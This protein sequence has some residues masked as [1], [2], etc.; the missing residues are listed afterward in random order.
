M[1]LA[2]TS[3]QLL[4]MLNARLLHFGLLARCRG[5][6]VKFVPGLLPLLH[7]FFGGL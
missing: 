5:G 3:H 6:L 2:E 7:G 1:A 4:K